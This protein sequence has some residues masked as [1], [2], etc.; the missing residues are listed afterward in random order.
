MAKKKKGENTGGGGA[1]PIE[2]IMQGGKDSLPVEKI[3]DAKV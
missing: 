3:I 1:L 2:P